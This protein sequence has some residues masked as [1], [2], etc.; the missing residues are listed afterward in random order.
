MPPVDFCCFA[1]VMSSLKV[2][3][4]LV[5]L[6][7]D[8]MHS[9]DYAV[10]RCLSAC[11]SVRLL[12]AGILS[13]RLNISS[14]FFLSSG[15]DTTLVF[16]VPNGLAIFW[17]EPLNGATNARGMKKLGFS[18][19]ISLYLRNNTRHGHS[20]YGSRIGN[21]TQAFDLYHFQWSWVTSNPDF[22]VTILFNV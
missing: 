15:S 2:I 19:N 11:L 6:P 18:T 21:H 22:N 9:A 8:A 7:R 5:F 20:Y 16:F 12:H 3:I 10:E 17:R 4:I 13:K 14:K 1:C